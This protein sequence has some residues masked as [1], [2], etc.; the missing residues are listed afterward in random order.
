MIMLK[1]TALCTIGAE[2]IAGLLSSE[3]GPDVALAILSAFF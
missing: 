3:L 2:L 1:L